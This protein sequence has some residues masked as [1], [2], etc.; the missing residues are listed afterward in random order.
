MIGQYREGDSVLHRMPAG[1]KIGALFI[2]GTAAFLVV[3]LRILAAM[4][5]AVIALYALARID[6]VTGLWQLRPV[7]WLLA[8]FF[9]VQWWLNGW[10]PALAVVLRVSMLVLLAALVSLTTRV[11]RMIAA[12]EKACA[13]LAIIG[14]DP[15][16]VGLAISMALRFIPVIAQVTADVREAQAARGI[17]RNVFAIAVPV[18]IRTLAMADD[19]ADAIE[20]RQ[21]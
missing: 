18:I 20:A 5:G 11:S 12:L 21:S 16:R 15:A 10:E 2:A 9:A 1:A 3:D 8:L 4:L 6:V 17:E 13:P 14:V 19:I 7:I